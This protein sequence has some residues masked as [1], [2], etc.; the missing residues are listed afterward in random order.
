MLTLSDELLTKTKIQNINYTK[1]NFYTNEIA[2]PVAFR[3]V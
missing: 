1:F 3:I 2:P